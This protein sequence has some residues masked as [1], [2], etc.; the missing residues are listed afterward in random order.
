MSTPPSPTPNH[1]QAGAPTP[2]LTGRLQGS[3][4]GGGARARRTLWSLAI[5]HLGIAVVAVPVTLLVSPS[6]IDARLAEPLTVYPVAGGL[7]LAIGQI[8]SCGKICAM[9]RA[10]TDRIDINQIARSL[11][12][13]EWSLILT[14]FPAGIQ[15]ILLF[16][17]PPTPQLFVLLALL[18][19]S[20]V[21]EGIDIGWLHHRMNRIGENIVTA[22]HHRLPLGTGLRI[23]TLHS[24]IVGMHAVLGAVAAIL[25]AATIV[26]ETRNATA[27]P[28]TMLVQI[29]AAT[30]ATA[31]PF[32]P[33]RGILLVR[34]AITG[35]TV[36][37]PTLRRAGA[38][39]ICAS[40]G[41]APLTALVIASLLATPASPDLA[42]GRFVLATIAVGIAA[43][44]LIELE[45]FQIGDI[46]KRFRRKD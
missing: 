29:L 10:T 17:G 14:L 30:A 33:I 34:A 28:L 43:T 18:T 4:R 35:D 39:F 12:R 9:A 19:I 21:L 37:S 1:A 32:L 31:V 22:E 40:T 13:S 8:L 27:T 16:A 45:R 44:H 3:I 2:L 38:S 5:G 20:L 46:P 23:R 36:H 26:T 15:W 41:A 11:R 24:T 25:L 42:V 6:I 7:F